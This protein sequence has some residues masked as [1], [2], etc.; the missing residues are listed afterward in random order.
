[1]MIRKFLSLFLCAAMLVLACA[2]SVPD[3]ENAATTEAAM[4]PAI[5]A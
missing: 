5:S 3:G 1:M 4:K 2:C